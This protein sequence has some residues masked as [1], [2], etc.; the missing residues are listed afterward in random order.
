MNHLLPLLIVGTLAG[1]A[2]LMNTNVENGPVFRAGKVPQTLDGS[3][4]YAARNAQ[5]DAVCLI[6]RLAGARPTV[7]VLQMDADCGEV[8][9]DMPTAVSWLDLEDGSA[10]LVDSGGRELLVFGPSDGFAF[11]SVTP[12]SLIVTLSALGNV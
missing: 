5:T 6:K 9:S 2:G 8:F 10:V 4:T 12:G 3:L 7:S 1:G 11:E